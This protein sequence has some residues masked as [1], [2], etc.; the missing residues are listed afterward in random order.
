[1]LQ[2]KV[3]GASVNRK[4]QKMF[5]KTFYFLIIDDITAYIVSAHVT[6]DVHQ[7][8]LLSCRLISELRQLSNAL[9][10]GACTM[11]S[12]NLFKP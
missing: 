7:L 4:G 3:R 11:Q 5:Y 1:M 10:L 6:L 8:T 12:T 9:D 2:R